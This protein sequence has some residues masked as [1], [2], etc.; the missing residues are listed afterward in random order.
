MTL[1]THLTTEQS[2]KLEWD[3]YTF[4]DTAN[5]MEMEYK[6][7]SNGLVVNYGLGMSMKTVIMVNFGFGIELMLK[8]IHYLT[9]GT[10]E[11]KSEV[12]CLY[13]IYS[14][15]YDETKSELSFMFNIWRNIT[16]HSMF[17][18]MG[19]KTGV[20]KITSLSNINNIQPSDEKTYLLEALLKTFDA[21]G[22]YSKRFSYE[23]FSRDKYYEIIYVKPFIP[24]L[25]AINRHYTF[26]M[27]CKFELNEDQVTEYMQNNKHS[28]DMPKDIRIY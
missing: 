19:N 5:I 10:L 25:N 26:Y 17:L 12:H 24:L 23:T 15:L 2:I 16:D 11:K 7:K 14:N 3:I 1:R 13:D 22:L 9:K 21:H 6:K 8:K 28:F 27:N 18:G 20:T 4:L